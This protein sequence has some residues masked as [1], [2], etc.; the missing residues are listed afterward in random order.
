MT[1]G[2]AGDQAATSAPAPSSG[3]K[4]PSGVSP[5]ARRVAGAR[6]NPSVVGVTPDPVPLWL[7]TMAGWIWRLLLIIVAVALVFWATSQVRLL[8]IALF[9]AFVFT[10]VL[11]P[12]VNMFHRVM[13]RWL[14]VLLTLLVAFAVVGGLVTYV[15][16]SVA[17]QWEDLANQFNAGLQQILDFLNGSPF[18][19]NL[20]LSDVNDWVDKGREWLTQHSG[21]IAS[22][23][24]SQAGSVAEVFTGLAL[25]IFCTIFFLARGTEMWT[26]FLNQMPAASREPLLAA[27]GAGWYTFSGY[28]RGTVIIALT[29]GILAGIWLT[30]LRVPLAAPL[31]V[32]VFIGAF[33]PLIGAPLAM[34]VAM[35]VALA[36]H[37]VWSAVLVGIGIAMIGQLEGHVLQPLVMG[38]QVSLHPVVVACSVTAGTLIG[39]LLGA[40]IAVPLVGVTWAVYSRLHTPDPP[41]E[42]DEPAEAVEPPPDATVPD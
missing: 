26:W 38:R 18:H 5:A 25:A 40:I 20:Q 30:I 23:A 32:L 7:R 10:S 24:F 39:G 42:P 3:A 9:V 41:M 19:L 16:A 34:V 36:T 15:V 6:R 27:G 13:W 28:A 2:A 22:T 8:F 37:G 14:A 31:A 21:D 12:V 35:I 17:G 33:I 11:R 29:D 1:N 4:P